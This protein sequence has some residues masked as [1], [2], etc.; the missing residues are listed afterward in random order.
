MGPVAL[1]GGEQGM[2]SLLAAFVA[3]TLGVAACGSSS[4]SSSKAAQNTAAKEAIEQIEVNWHKASSKKDV[5]LMMSLWAPNATFTVGGK[6]YS[7]KAEIQNFFAHV[8]APF[9]IGHDWVSDTP[10]YK[11]RV[12]VTGDKGTIYFEC[13]YVDV[14]TG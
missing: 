6:T 12:T 11:E 9:M 8:A 2:R 1:R 13:H 10:A 4:S 14:A 7:G 5:A 3:A